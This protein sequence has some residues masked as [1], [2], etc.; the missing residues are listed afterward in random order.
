M[1]QRKNG[2]KKILSHFVSEAKKKI[3]VQK[4]ILFGSYANGTPKP[5]SDIDVAVISPKFSR[6]NELERIKLLLD[7]AHR[8]KCELPVDIETFGYTPEEYEKATYFDF[9][10]VIKNTGKVIYSS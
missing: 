3:P 8:I 4:V 2:L 10:G 1:V 6:M 9:L 5:T 7:C